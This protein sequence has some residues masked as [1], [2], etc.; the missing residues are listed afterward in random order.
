M[1]DV[2]TA[3]IRALVS[4]LRDHAKDVR[5]WGTAHVNEALSMQWHSTSSQ[6]FEVRTSSD[7]SALFQAAAR[8]D[9]IADAMSAHADAVDA[10]QAAAAQEATQG[11]GPGQAAN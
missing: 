7:Q 6:A 5:D 11:Q 10:A 8:V 9:S 4:G 3:A 2:D 1:A